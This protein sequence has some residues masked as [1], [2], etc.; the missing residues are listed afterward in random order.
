MR[1]PGVLAKTVATLDVLSSRLVELGVG[2]GWHADEYDACG[3]DFRRRGAVLDDVIGAC[4]TLWGGPDAT[5]S[6]TTASFVSLNSVPLPVQ[7]R[8]PILFAGSL[9]GRNVAR[10]VADG[11]GWIPVMGADPA[12]VAAGIALLDTVATK[13]AGRNARFLVRC[14]LA[15]V[16]DD[17]GSPDVDATLA[18]IPALLDAGVTDVQFPLPYF[19]SN[20]SRADRAAAA[21]CRR[22]AQL[23]GDAQSPDLVRSSSDMSTA[24]GGRLRRSPRPRPHDEPVG[25]LRDVDP[26]ATGR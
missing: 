15:P 23:R 9:H 16:F 8:I 3:V 20:P 22:L 21:R 19:A 17:R 26:R 7:E 5:Y 12:V 4:P 1:T 24:S 18:S 6:S 10:I 11:D 2:V 14:E 13:R 25:P